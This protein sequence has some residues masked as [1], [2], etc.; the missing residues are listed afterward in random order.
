MLTCA[1]ACLKPQLAP[2]DDDPQGRYDLHMVQSEE[3]E[4]PPTSCDRHVELVREV[5][6]TRPHTKVASLSVTCPPNDAAEC[7]ER[8]TRRA[9]ELEADAVLLEEGDFTG[10]AEGVGNPRDRSLGGTAIRWTAD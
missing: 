3:R 4:P 7:E 10:P 1:T 5:D 8:L 6:A 2:A 9:C